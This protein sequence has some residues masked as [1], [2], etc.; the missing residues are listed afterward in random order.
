MEIF[1]KVTMNT[2]VYRFGYFLIGHFITIFHIVINFFRNSNYFT[3]SA[4]FIIFQIACKFA[5]KTVILW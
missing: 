4:T 3:I 2:I 5:S 1:Y